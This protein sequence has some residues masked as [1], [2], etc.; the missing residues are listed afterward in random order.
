MRHKVVAIFLVFLVINLGYAY[1]EKVYT[2]NFSVLGQCPT[3]FNP[4]IKYCAISSG[5]SFTPSNTTASV[6]I[7]EIIF[8]K[9]NSTNVSFSNVV[10]R[11]PAYWNYTLATI[12]NGTLTNL[13]M[14]SSHPFCL[15]NIIRKLDGTFHNLLI[16]PNSTI[17]GYFMWSHNI[18]IELEYYLINISIPSISKEGN[19]LTC[20][21]NITTD[22][23]GAD[24]STNFTF[25]RNGET[26]SN[27]TGSKTCLNSTECQYSV[28]V[29]NLSG[30]WT[31]EVFSGDWSVRSEILAVDSQIEITEDPFQTDNS[32]SEHSFIARARAKDLDGISDISSCFVSSELCGP[33]YLEPT[34]NEN[35]IECRA[36][37][38]SQNESEISLSF[39]FSDTQG[40]N[41]S[42][43]ETAFA[44]PNSPP[45][46]S[47]SNITLVSP[48]STR[49]YAEFSCVSE[50][51]DPDGDS[52]TELYLFYSTGFGTLRDYSDNSTFHCRESEF[53]LK[54]EEIKCKTNAVDELGRS[55]DRLSDGLV[56]IANAPP[57]KVNF[58]TQNGSVFNSSSIQ[59]L[60]SASLDEDEDEVSYVFWLSEGSSY[61][62][63]GAPLNLSNLSDG[64]YIL[65]GRSTDGELESQE[66]EL[67]FSVS[68]VRTTTT[69]TAITTTTISSGGGFPPVSTSIVSTT[70]TILPTS[71]PI[72]G[73][74]TE[75]GNRSVLVTI[76]NP[77]NSSVFLEYDKSVISCYPDEIPAEKSAIIS[78]QFSEKFRDRPVS[79]E[80]TNGTTAI[81]QFEL[82]TDTGKTSE[83]A[84]A[85]IERLFR[86]WTNCFD[87]RAKELVDSLQE[88]L[89][90][91]KILGGNRT[92]LD[93]LVASAE[94]Y[95]I[96][97][98]CQW[99]ASNGSFGSAGNS[100]S[101]GRL[102]T[103]LFVAEPKAPSENENFF[104]KLL[105]TIIAF[106]SGIFLK[107]KSF[108]G[109]T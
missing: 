7:P 103:P 35:E 86:I 38:S 80:I 102:P 58:Q 77:R 18:S 107:I 14:C 50:T 52:F 16:F 61:S 63:E 94:S 55:T 21:S 34:G 92:E 19:F 69:T 41:I 71:F 36:T 104:T 76:E 64:N 44:T 26:V 9:L 1:K 67:Y 53:C 66:E 37:C 5:S 20:S 82:W 10:Y 78:C 32:T 72:I 97:S 3:Y 99:T 2:Q 60:F 39:V 13:R 98:N 30:N 24:L 59:I 27:M 91:E 88:A 75:S 105:N 62:S 28:D 17:P 11:S 101:T 89:D 109:F 70:T 47:G 49:K 57:E 6:Y 79:I 40:R 95:E 4:P 42:T 29:Q 8:S 48:N 108:L 33:T 56:A 51:T 12:S 96:H 45:S 25:M 84:R 23:S 85:Q 43:S 15:E 68:S 106:F 54:G 83:R 100:S 65:K 22:F 31:C 81:S 90:R 74:P 46:I 73:T 87:S 93:S